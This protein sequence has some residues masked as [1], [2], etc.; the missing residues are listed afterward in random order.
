[1]GARVPTVAALGA[2]GAPEPCPRLLL[3]RCHRLTFRTDEL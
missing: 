3:L 1:M 2:S